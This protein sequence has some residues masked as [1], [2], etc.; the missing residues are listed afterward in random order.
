MHER[1]LP[2]KVVDVFPLSSGKWERIN[3]EDP[4]NP[5]KKWGVRAL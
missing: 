3:P 2:P 5:V 4:V 1:V